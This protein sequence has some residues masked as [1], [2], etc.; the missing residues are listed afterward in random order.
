MRI[1][2]C[3]TL[4]VLCLLPC[5][6][7]FAG[8]AVSLSPEVMTITSNEEFRAAWESDE[9]SRIMGESVLSDLRS[10]KISGLKLNAL[11]SAESIAEVN[12]V[13]D[14]L[15]SI[16]ERADNSAAEESLLAAQILERAAVIN[17][18]GLTKKEESL[19][20][21]VNSLP[22][23]CGPLKTAGFACG[24][25]PA[26][27]VTIYV[28]VA[29][30]NST[31]GTFTFAAA[32]AAKNI[33]VRFVASI[34][35]CKGFETIHA[36]YYR[37]FLYMRDDTG[38]ASCINKTYCPPAFCLHLYNSYH[39]IIQNNRLQ[40]TLIHQIAHFR[41]VACIA[42]PVKAGIMKFC[43]TNIT[44]REDASLTPDYFPRKLDKVGMI[45]FIPPLSFCRGDFR[46]NL[47][48]HNIM[49]GFHEEA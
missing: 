31:S 7:S 23:G 35:P 11:C 12:L 28:A 9:N 47:K 46:I 48:T 40:N 38:D 33:S 18:T 30:V 26:D 49:E 41:G 10:G 8:E 14:K 1:F 21:T 20:K 13:R 39:P 34:D 42:N 15:L 5:G 36:D 45:C 24:A 32:T 4:L 6:K 37:L 19:V 25:I 44:P 17:I 2:Y 43:I 3:I 27:S 22:A 16:I 29:A